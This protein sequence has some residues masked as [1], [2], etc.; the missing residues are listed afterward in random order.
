ML[1]SFLKL[2]F[3]TLWKNKLYSL[4]NV[5]GLAIGIAASVLILLWV[6]DE[7]AFDGFLR[8][9]DRL[10]QVMVHAQFDGK[11]NTWSSVPLPTYEAMKTADH[12]IVGSAVTGWGS[13][14]LLT[15][16]DKRLLRD[17]LFVSEEFLEMFEFPLASG[18][19]QTVLDE[20]QSIVLSESLAQALFPN[21]DPI[22]K[23]IRLDDEH[24]LMVSGLLVDVPDH[25]TFQFDYL[26]TWKFREQ[27]NPWVVRNKDNWGNY[28]FQ[29]FIELAD[30]S[31]AGQAGMAISD[32]LTKNGQEDIER[33][34]FLHPLSKWHLHANWENGQNTGGQ[35]D[36]VRLFT[37]IAILILIIACI[38]FMNLSTARSENRMREVGIRKSVGAR[39]IQIITQF[40]GES[41]IIS[42]LA[43]ALALL[44]VFLFLGPF[45]QLVD[46][47]LEIDLTSPT[48][49]MGSLSIILVT[50]LLSGSYPALYLSSFKPTTIL[51]GVIKVG[52]GADLPRKALVVLQFGFAILLMMGSFV[53]YRQ[54]NLVQ[55]RQLGYD[56]NN[57]VNFQRTDELDKN[58]E[59]LKT[60]LLQA[61]LIESMT[62]SN[63]RVTSINS[64][65]FLG[66]PG[67]PEEQK[68][69]FTTITTDYDY[70]K[71]Y[72]IK[73]LA[74]R[75]FSREFTT[76][77][78]AIVI[79]KAALDLMG[80]DDPI[81]TQ[82]DLWGGKRKLI[83]V[84]DN[85]LMGSLFREVK[86]LFMVMDDWGGVMTARLTRGH[87][88]RQTLEKIEQVFSKYN[89]AYPFE[90]TFVDDD[91]EEKF[92]TIRLTQHLASIFTFL[93]L[94][95]TGLGLF[96][97]ASFMAAQ[98]TKEI[99]I[100]KVLGASV[101][102]LVA[103]MSR[104]FSKLVL[105]ALAIALPVTWW[106]L[107]NYLERY[108]LRVSIEWWLFVVVAL[109]LLTFTLFIVG[110]KA[111][112]AALSNPA[113]S[114]R[115]M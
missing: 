16:G 112:R 86:P 53:V 1:K 31:D 69:I 79:N 98:R 35:I 66:W 25:S 15:V 9:G 26:L 13:E 36:Y 42:I 71:T 2:T 67:K 52:K 43:F 44:I 4:I 51:K 28:S 24:D 38:N 30:A 3:R 18:Q 72:D 11:I 48:F 57:L 14:H 45:N 54:I 90:Y 95:I 27:I 17:G 81:G 82:L 41:L 102:S 70:A 59:V 50:G 76:D 29:V 32:M 92:A 85:V 108:P 103:L 115:D 64:N 83:G 88:V 93:A 109:T 80:L 97:L 55:N 77:T 34:L 47:N 87:D 63:S 111:R 20:P 114:L 89:P 58:Y 61:G 40:L 74:G 7:L 73:I 6:G 12:R 23:I 56:Q 65:N 68:V 37:M 110:G 78:S 107:D 62:R 104:E 101:T 113:N 21:S 106:L 96:G 60:E 33:E 91:F 99:G 39:R 22:G 8:K 105:L 94:F 100:R 84:I 10:Q 49:I 5:A 19:P 75:D 46:K